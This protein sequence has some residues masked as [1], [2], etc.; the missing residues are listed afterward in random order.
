MDYKTVFINLC[1]VLQQNRSWIKGLG[2]NPFTHS[3]PFTHSLTAV[4]F[5]R[6][7]RRRVPSDSEKHRRV[8][9]SSNVCHSHEWRVDTASGLTLAVRHAVGKKIAC[10]HGLRSEGVKDEYC[11]TLCV[12][13]TFTGQNEFDCFWLV[14]ALSCIVEGGQNDSQNQSKMPLYVCSVGS[15]VK[16]QTID[17]FLPLLLVATKATVG[18]F[19]PNILRSISNVRYRQS[20]QPEWIFRISYRNLPKIR[21]YGHVQINTEFWKTTTQNAHKQWTPTSMQ[22]PIHLHRIPALFCLGRIRTHSPL[23]PCIQCVHHGVR[24]HFQCMHTRPPIKI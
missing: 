4:P 24:A 10:I 18:G 11:Q 20:R 12:V 1:L 8:Y 22:R 17:W 21:Q 16:K 15:T 7:H 14:R 2:K 23:M 3:I 19:I 13:S 9:T 6:G 5:V